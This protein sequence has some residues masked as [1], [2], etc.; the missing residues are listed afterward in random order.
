MKPTPFSIL[1]S[2]SVSSITYFLSSTPIVK[3]ITKAKHQIKEVLVTSAK[4][5]ETG[6]ILLVIVVAKGTEMAIEIN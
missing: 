4:D 6:F 1:F 3:V 5:L 2:K